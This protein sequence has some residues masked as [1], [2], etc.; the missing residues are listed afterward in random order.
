MLLDIVATSFTI[1]TNADLGSTTVWR[2]PCNDSQGGL[3]QHSFNEAAK[4][5]LS[6]VATVEALDLITNPA[7]REKTV[8]LSV[9]GET[10]EVEVTGFDYGANWCGWED[11]DITGYHGP[12]G[13]KLL[14]QIPITANTDAVGGPNVATNTPDSGLTIKDDEGNI[15]D[16]Y[17]FISPKISLPVNVHIK[18]EGLKPGESAKFMIQKA[19]I[20][21]S[22]DISE[23]AEEDWEYV[24]TVF[25]TNGPYAQRD[26]GDPVVKVRGLPANEDGVDE[27][28]NPVRYNLIY[29][30]SEEEWSWSYTLDTEPQ[31]T[32]TQHVDNPFLFSNTER[33]NIDVI[34]RH[35][36]TKATNIFK[37]GVVTGNVH[38]DDSKLNNRGG[39][40]SE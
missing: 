32:D 17:T 24:S 5:Q 10:G 37:P 21:A 4:E 33:D 29:R 27:E 7:Q 14:L 2:V 12:H 23:I 15:V 28:N 40:P 20:P 35:A 8:C 3:I 9:D 26:K 39:T 13:Y 16:E 18:K 1:S 31:F 38:Y 34:V 30:I 22:G 25:V 19:R 11:D 6:T 36:E